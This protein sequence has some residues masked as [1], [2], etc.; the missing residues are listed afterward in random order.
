MDTPYD[1][2]VARSPLPE[3]V[4]RRQFDRVNQQPVVLTRTPVRPVEQ[5]E[6]LPRVFLF[7]MDG[8]LARIDPANPRDPYD[9]SRAHED[10]EVGPVATVFD[11]MSCVDKII[12]TGRFNRHLGVTEK[13]LTQHGLNDYKAIYTRADG[14]HRQDAAVKYD[15][16]RE[17][18]KNYYVIGVFDDREQV[19]DMWRTAGIH[20]F[21]VGQGKA[22]F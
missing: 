22:K 10:L 5:D 7:D 16:L 3:A 18:V 9:A 20:V 15:M 4:V 21:D 8:T 2:C 17:I 11:E 14:D 1:V 19:I 12:T 6:T 13:W